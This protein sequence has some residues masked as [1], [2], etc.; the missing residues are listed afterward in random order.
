MS[1]RGGDSFSDKARAGPSLV[2][3]SY[4]EELP[5]RAAVQCKK[6]PVEVRQ[7]L[8]ASPGLLSPHLEG[9]FSFVTSL[10]LIPSSG[11]DFL[12]LECSTVC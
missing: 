12:H 8:R 1:G 6:L 7:P 10:H 9:C 2:G 4:K 11:L 5:N 3:G